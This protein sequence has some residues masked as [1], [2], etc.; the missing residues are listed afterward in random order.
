MA[1]VHISS[2]IIKPFTSEG[3]V[4]VWLKKVGVVA[5]LQIVDDVA[6]LLPLYLVGRHTGSLYRDGRRRPKEHKSD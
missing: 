6:S 5:V 4:I 1:K 2:N 3:D